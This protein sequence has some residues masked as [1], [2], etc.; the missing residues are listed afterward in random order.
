MLDNLYHSI[1]S[2]PIAKVLLLVWIVFAT[3]YVVVGEYNRINRFVAQVAFNNGMSNAV[4][5]LIQQASTCQ[6]VPISAGNAKMTLISVE[7]LQG[8]SEGQPAEA[9]AEG[10]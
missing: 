8:A 3:V 9:P 10:E 1:R 5:Q 4:V 2:L 7:C 6:A